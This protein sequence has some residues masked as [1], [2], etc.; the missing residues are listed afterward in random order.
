MAAGQPGSGR[1]RTPDPTPDPTPQTPSLC[2]RRAGEAEAALV[3]AGQRFRAV[4]ERDPGDGRALANWG[5][6][7]CVRAE[8]APDAQV[9]MGSVER[10][11]NPETQLPKPDA[12]VRGLSGTVATLPGGQKD[13]HTAVS[14]CLHLG[15]ELM[16]NLQSCAAQVAAALYEAAVAKFE[17][18]LEGDPRARPVLRGAALALLGLARAQPDPAARATR[19]L[20][21]VAI[22]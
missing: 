15:C 2:C 1:S 5:R 19:Q 18:V 21:E 12:Q 14:L 11:R 13:C 6:A 4:A 10:A 7:L 9:R 3:A 16:T 22:P 20:L 8:L 17:A